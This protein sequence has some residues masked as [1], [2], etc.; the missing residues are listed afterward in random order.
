MLG[1]RLLWVFFP[2]RLNR[3]LSDIVNNMLKAPELEFTIIT[4]GK[5]DYVLSWGTEDKASN[6]QAVFAMRNCILKNIIIVTAW[7]WE[8]ASIFSDI[9]E[10]QLTECFQMISETRDEAR[11]Q[12]CALHERGELLCMGQQGSSHG[13][14]WNTSLIS[15]EPTWL[16]LHTSHKMVIQ[17]QAESLLA[18]LG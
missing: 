18:S 8:A 16:L 5:P 17:M 2:P 9:P 7:R 6:R 4:G 10:K 12:S 3:V 14:P 11:V 1:C 15:S 13:L